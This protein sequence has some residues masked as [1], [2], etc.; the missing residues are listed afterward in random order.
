MRGVNLKRFRF[1]LRALLCGVAVIAAIAGW[2]GNEIYQSR[3]E[4]RAIAMVRQSGGDVRFDCSI[5]DVPYCDSCCTESIFR[6]WL[7]TTFGNT[8][9]G[10]VRTV[11]CG[12]ATNLK[13]ISELRKLNHLVIVGFLDASLDG[14]IVEQ[15]GERDRVRH[16]KF[17][18][19]TW[20]GNAFQSLATLEHI[21]GLEIVPVGMSR[22]D[23]SSVQGLRR[24][25]LLKLE[26]ATVDVDSLGKLQGISSIEHLSLRYSNCTGEF[27]TLK[28]FSQL[29]NLNLQGTRIGDQHVPILAE[30][31]Q[32]QMLDVQDTHLSE[33]GLRELE[34]ALPRCHVTSSMSLSQNGGP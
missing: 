30:M 17:Y 32:L 20:N 8:L 29:T 6:R 34:L 3:V 22:V 23:V 25:R 19:C 4:H 28:K 9:F 21:E 12:K 13:T 1:R 27:G 18:R 2:L 15:L 26:Y 10:R 24:L 11:A 33:D 5:Y 7:R 16:V 14:Q 31:K